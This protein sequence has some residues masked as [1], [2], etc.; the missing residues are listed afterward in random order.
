[1]ARDSQG[2]ENLIPDAGWSEGGQHEWTAS[3]DGFA[4]AGFGGD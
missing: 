2:A 4:V 1:M 3:I